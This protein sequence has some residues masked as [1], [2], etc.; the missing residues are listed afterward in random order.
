MDAGIL[1]N[2]LKN[3]IENEREKILLLKNKYTQK[4]DEKNEMEKLLRKC[5]NDYKQD[6]WEIKTNMRY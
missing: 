3:N 4:L 5:I 2:K 6:L 1:I